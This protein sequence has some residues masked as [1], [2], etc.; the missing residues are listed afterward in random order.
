MISLFRLF[1]TLHRSSQVT[2]WHS[3]P[4]ITQPF[5]SLLFSS[6]QSHLSVKYFKLT[7]PTSY[8]HTIDVLR[9]LAVFEKDQ[10]KTK[11][12]KKFYSLCLLKFS[13]FPSR[14]YRLCLS[15]FP[16]LSFFYEFTL[17]IL[18]L[19]SYLFL[20]NNRNLGKLVIE[21]FTNNWYI[22]KDF[23]VLLDSKSTLFSFIQ[24]LPLPFFVSLTST[25]FTLNNNLTSLNW[26]PSVT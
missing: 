7:F 19:V 15:I 22:R 14:F 1:V 6:R 5:T 25:I 3:L 17:S 21:L 16:I 13:T 18:S 10:N 26:N 23:Y 8:D 24:T 12:S 2:P 4:Y 11:Q 9:N 20:H